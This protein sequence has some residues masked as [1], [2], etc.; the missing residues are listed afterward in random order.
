MQPH[1]FSQPFKALT[2]QSRPRCL[3]LAMT[4]MAAMLAGCDSDAPSVSDDFPPLD[5][6]Q[7]PVIPPVCPG[8]PECPTEPPVDP[9][10]ST[11]VYIDS[12]VGNI[13]YQTQSQSGRST[14]AGE[15]L[16]INAETVTFSIGDVVL[17]ATLAK[18]VITPLDIAQ[19]TSITDTV[20]TNIVRLMLSLDED[21]D[22]TNGIWIPEQAHSPGLVAL[23]F[24]FSSPTFEDDVMNLVAN[25]G[26][27][28]TALV[29]VPTA[30]QHLGET[31]ADFPEAMAG[32]DQFVAS[33]GG[34]N[35]ALLD[36]SASTDPQDRE[37]SYQWSIVSQPDCVNCAT[38]TNANSSQASIVGM[39]Q[40]GGYVVE[41]VVSNGS[42]SNADQVTI[43]LGAPAAGVFS[44]SGVITE[45]EGALASLAPVGTEFNGDVDYDSNTVTSLLVVLGGFCFTDDAFG[46]PPSSPTCNLLGKS[47][48]PV[49]T[50]G[51]DLYVGDPA[52][53]NSTFQQAGS[54]FNVT[55]GGTIEIIS[56][57]PTFGIIIF[58]L[59]WCL[60]RTAQAC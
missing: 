6:T 40:P 10:I 50:T 35:D 48:V 26:S 2:S 46:L 55:T 11:G 56:Y 18:A 24:S 23:P 51:Q 9:V 47:A 52:P 39:R 41:L 45:G 37:L 8:D 29:D 15:Y 31:L 20:V 19:S 38:L 43:T 54:D 3:L 21:G 59:P 57:S 1:F 44:L 30:V 13:S 58:L 22:P 7:P 42:S 17:P 33:S 12:E 5:V 60:T 14:V 4:V 16:Y 34:D 28:T 53:P 27:V 36:G 49:L 25:S 32:D